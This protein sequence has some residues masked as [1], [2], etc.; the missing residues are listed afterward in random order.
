MKCIVICNG[1]SISE[2]LLEEYR[3]KN[4]FLICADGGADKLRELKTVPDILIGDF[5]SISEETMNLYRKNGVE[6]LNFPPEK[7]YTDSELAVETA[8]NRGFKEIVILGG[9]GSRMDHTFA[10]IQLLKKIYDCGC[11]GIIADENNRIQLISDN[12]SLENPGGYRVTLLP[13]TP[14]VEGIT[15]K[16]LYYP[17]ENFT[18]V[19]GSTRGVSNEFIGEKASVNIT[20]GLLL[21]FLSRD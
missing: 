13:L 16:G 8:V 5:D 17:L 10:N 7:D 6:I 3:D 4:T 21:V 1:N 20:G 9:I 2:E 11:K 19:Q 15:T 18:M 14:S 12:I